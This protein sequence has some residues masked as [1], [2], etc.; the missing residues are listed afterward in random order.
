ME[1][2]AE[3]YIKQR[4]SEPATA[5]DVREWEWMVLGWDVQLT[6]GFVLKF[7]YQ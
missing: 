5:A 3:A 6:Q 4:G 7:K 1:G 2:E